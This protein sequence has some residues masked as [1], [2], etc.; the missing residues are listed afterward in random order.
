MK[1]D[2]EA[3][4]IKTLHNEYLEALRAKRRDFLKTISKIRNEDEKSVASREVESVFKEFSQ[5]AL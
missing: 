5:R 2:N 4:L 1:I 3:K